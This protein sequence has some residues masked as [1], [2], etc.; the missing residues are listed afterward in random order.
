M[1]NAQIF[2]ERVRYYRVLRGW[3]QEDLGQRIGQ[4]V[5]TISRIE[6][7]TQNLTSEV[8]LALAKALEVHPTAFFTEDKEESH[9]YNL[10]LLVMLFRSSRRLPE[11]VLKLFVSMV[12]EVEEALSA[13]DS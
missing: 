11:S 6:N 5:P 13:Q 7:V 4:S 8:I 10:A 12:E 9:F 1:M 2:G 3:D